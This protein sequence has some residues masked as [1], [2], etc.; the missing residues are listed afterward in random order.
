[1]RSGVVAL[2][3]QVLEKTPNQ[4]LESAP[5]L[6]FLLE[7]ETGKSFHSFAYFSFSDAQLVTVR[8]SLGATRVMHNTF[9]E[10]PKYSFD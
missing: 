8:D 5:K 2:S 1:M 10:K 7:N 4:Y 3:R 6:Y 9:N